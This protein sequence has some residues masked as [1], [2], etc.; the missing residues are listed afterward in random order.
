ML[1]ST[2]VHLPGRDAGDPI[3]L[4][5]LPA[6]VAD[7]H[8]RDALRAL[9]VNPDGGVVALALEHLEDVLRRPEQAMQLLQPFVEASRPPRSWNNV[10]AVQRAALALHVGFLVGRP[11]LDVPVALRVANI[12]AGAG[13]VGVSFCSPTLAAVLHS[14]R[15]TYRELET[16]LSTE[17]A[18]NLA[19]LANVEAI[20]D[21]QASQAHTQGTA[22]R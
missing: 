4:T 11:Q 3:T 5:E 1:K 18:F 10:M 14:G 8:A 16:V 13:D 17:D 9:G 7:R 2:T 21:W 19:E 22:N 15:A 6:L 12:R 20:R